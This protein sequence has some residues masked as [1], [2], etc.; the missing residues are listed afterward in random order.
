MPRHED[1]EDTTEEIIERAV[2]E[3]V[4]VAKA[5]NGLSVVRQWWPVITTAVLALV[6]YIKLQGTVESLE[7]NVGELNNHRSSTDAQFTALKIEQTKVQGQ[8]EA[9]TLM[10]KQLQETATRI[11]R[12]LEK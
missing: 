5:K 9:L 12:K 2:A 4:A 3:K 8:I 1:H 11:E 6:G 10:I 7:K